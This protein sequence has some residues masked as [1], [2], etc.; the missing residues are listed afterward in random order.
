MSEPVIITMVIQ[1]KP[2]VADAACSGFPAGVEATR[3]FKGFRDLKVRR[4]AEDA[5]RVIII[6][7]WDSKEDYQAYVAWRMTEAGA[8]AFAATLAGPPQV[9]C[10]PVKIV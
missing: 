3:K 7:E 9:D 6:E 8:E 4:N 10:W 1:F 2:E 5:S